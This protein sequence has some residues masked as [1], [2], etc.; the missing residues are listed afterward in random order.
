[1]PHDVLDF[2]LGDSLAGSAFIGQRS[3]LEWL[4]TDEWISVL[5]LSE[6]EDFAINLNVS[7]FGATGGGMVNS[8]R[9]DCSFKSLPQHIMSH[10]ERWK[11]W[12]SSSHPELESLPGGE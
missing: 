2:I 10:P 4:P 11:Q 5:A 6:I 1:M 3:P 7:D 12:Y 8:S 9:G